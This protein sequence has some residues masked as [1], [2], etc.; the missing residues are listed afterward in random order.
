MKPLVV[1]MASNGGNE[2]KKMLLQQIKR[3]FKHGSII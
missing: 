1:P 2:L 3:W